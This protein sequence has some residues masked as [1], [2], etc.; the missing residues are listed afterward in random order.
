[1]GVRP[2][3]TLRGARL[4]WSL[5]CL[6]RGRS[7]PEMWGGGGGGGGETFLTVLVAFWLCSSWEWEDGGWEQV[8][9]YIERMKEGIASFQAR[10]GPS[11]TQEAESLRAQWMGNLRAN[12]GPFSEQA[13]APAARVLWWRAEK[14]SKQTAKAS[15][16]M[17]CNEGAF[18]R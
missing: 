18:S 4:W 8:Q 12:T 14:G 1:M 11:T 3:P 6:S 15:Q 9:G 7:R 17:R 5:C 16:E 10:I 2:G 13:F